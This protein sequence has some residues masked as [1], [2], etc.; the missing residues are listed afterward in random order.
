MKKKI[1]LI[2]GIALFIVWL[3]LS[4]MNNAC[5]AVIGIAALAASVLLLAGTEYVG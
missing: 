3:A 1:R 5:L 4:C 2:S